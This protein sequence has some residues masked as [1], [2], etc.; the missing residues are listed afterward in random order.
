MAKA[1]SLNL[2][3]IFW[4]GFAHGHIWIFRR[5]RRLLD[6]KW[7]R[8]GGHAKLVFE[9][10][11]HVGTQMPEPADWKPL[12]GLAVAIERRAERYTPSPSPK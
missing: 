4:V 5:V 8:I 2:A 10:S 7:F 12:S 3:R 1:M 9:G 11:I 6:G